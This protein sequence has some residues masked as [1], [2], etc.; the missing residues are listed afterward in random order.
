MGMTE[1]RQMQRRLPFTSK[2]THP[3][4]GA[5]ILPLWCQALPHVCGHGTAAHSLHTD[6]P[7][8]VAQMCEFSFI[9]LR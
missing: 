5:A 3:K 9:T 4:A 1:S 2:R 6:T 7:M 8:E